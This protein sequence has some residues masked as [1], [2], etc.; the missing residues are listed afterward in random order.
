MVIMR[1]S[2]Y[3]HKLDELIRDGSKFTTCNDK[4]TD[5]IK[6][7]L[8]AIAKIYKNESHKLYKNLKRTSK[9]TCGHLYGL[10]KVHKN[11][12][13]PPFNESIPAFIK[14]LHLVL[15]LIIL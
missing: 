11:G 5:T 13:D 8:N 6:Q 2:E 15:R 10:P 3:N 4:Q 7:K 9:Y 1:T 12:N 14:I